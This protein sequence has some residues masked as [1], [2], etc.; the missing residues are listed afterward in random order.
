MFTGHY[1]PGFA[2]NAQEKRLPLWLLFIAV[3]FVDVLWA[4]FVLLGIEKVRIVPG[5][6]AASPLDL[7]YMP[8]THSLV[9]ALSWSLLAMVL[10]QMVPRLRGART[11]LILAAAVF[12]HWILDLI[13]HRPDLALYDSAYK[14]GFGLWNYRV[15][16]F[17][18]E[19]A[20]LFGGGAL[21]MKAAPRRGKAVVFLIVLA[22]LQF[23]GTFAFPPPPSDRGA[24][25]TALAM[26]V[27]LALLAAWA[28]RSQRKDDAAANRQQIPFAG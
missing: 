17:V 3:Q 24:A 15:A 20:V 2:A 18:L 13:V 9:G 22:A 10:C 28:D 11:G 1:G 16:S 12:S 6:T 7:Y 8:Y 5:I 26:Y 21:Y 4:I 14:M 23:V 25:L 19:M 27:L